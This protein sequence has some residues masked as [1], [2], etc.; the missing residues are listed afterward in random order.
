MLPAWSFMLC[1]GQ[2]KMQKDLPAAVIMH[3]PMK[4]WL[5][6]FIHLHNFK[7]VN[8]PINWL[9]LNVSAQ[10]I[11]RGN[12]FGSYFTDLLEAFDYPPPPCGY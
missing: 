12:A 7:I 10:T 8:D 6:R 4:K 5:S 9:L 2:N 3:K 1:C 11:T